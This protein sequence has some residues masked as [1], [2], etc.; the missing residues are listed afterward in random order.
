MSST[1]LTN[2]KPLVILVDGK[3]VFRGTITELAIAP[4]LS[5]SP[6]GGEKMVTWYAGEGEI[7]ARFV[8][9]YEAGWPGWE[10]REPVSNHRAPA[11]DPDDDYRG[12][13]AR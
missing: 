3:E 2:A 5:E 13:F 8:G 7:R 10:P 4:E 9:E 12:E 11:E 1:I 6:C